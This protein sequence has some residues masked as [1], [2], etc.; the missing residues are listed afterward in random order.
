MR[1][2]RRPVVEVED[3]IPDTREEA[4]E[5]FDALMTLDG[6]LP[7]SART[8]VGTLQTLPAKYPRGLSALLSGYRKHLARIDKP[9]RY[10]V[11]KRAK[12]STLSWVAA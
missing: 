8:I 11:R 9:P 4:V 6:F 7:G 3:F 10:V 12:R 2:G 5:L 1:P